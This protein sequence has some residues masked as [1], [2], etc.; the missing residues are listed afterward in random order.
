MEMSLPNLKW[1][2]TRNNRLYLPKLFLRAFYTRQLS[3]EHEKFLQ[4]ADK[5]A[6]AKDRSPILQAQKLKLLHS[7]IIYS[8]ICLP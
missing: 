8:N 5:L 6:I 1:L 2:T 7:C 4:S 3:T